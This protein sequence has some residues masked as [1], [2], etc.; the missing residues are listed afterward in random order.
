MQELRIDEGDK[1]KQRDSG[2][3]S[4]E[5][6]SAISDGLYYYEQVSAITNSTFLIRLF[7]VQLQP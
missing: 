4:T 3:I 2:P 6:A 7:L 1:V 5:Q